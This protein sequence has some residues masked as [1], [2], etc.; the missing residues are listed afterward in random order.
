MWKEGGRAFSQ[1][2]CGK[3]ETSCRGSLT[4]RLMISPR[5]PVRHH[6]AKQFALEIGEEM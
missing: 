6:K 5:E 3:S 2:P 4:A 1:E